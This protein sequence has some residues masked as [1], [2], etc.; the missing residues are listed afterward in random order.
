MKKKWIG[1]LYYAGPIRTKLLLKMKL[2]TFLLCL[3]VA[4][5]AS[6]TYSQQ[7]KFTMN[8]EN[9][10]V[11]QVFQKVE[12]NSEFI[13]LYSEQSVDLTREVTVSVTNKTVSD[14][15]DQL[16][17]GT[18]NYYEIN[19]RQISILEKKVETTPLN[20]TIPEVKDKEQ[21]QKKSI[22]GKVTDTNGEPLPGVTVVVKGTTIGITTDFD[23]NYA[24]EV[25]VDAEILSFS[26]VGMK[27]QDVIIA[28]QTQIS[29]TLEEETIGLEEVVAIGYGVQKKKLTTGANAQVTG[30]VLFKQNTTETLSALQGQASGIQIS[31]NS[32]QPGSDF[33]INI[34]GLGTNG[35]ATPLYV[36]DGIPTSSIS[37]LSP[38]D[39]ES[40]DVLKDAASAAIY[41]ARA[42]N[43]VVLVTTKQ[44]KAGK[45]TI[46]LDSYYGWQNLYKKLDLLNA[47]EYAMI[48]NESWVSAGNNSLYDPLNP[49][50]FA[51]TVPNWDKIQNGIWMGTDWL[52]EIRVKNAPTQN[53]SLNITGGTDKS[54]Y[55][56]GIS[57]NQQKGILGKPV[58]SNYERV[59][60][61]INSDH[62]LIE[63]NELTILK[64]GENLNFSMSK[65]NSLPTGSA[66]YNFLTRF[67][68]MHPFSSAY[69]EEG[70]YKDAIPWSTSGAH[71]NPVG[72]TDYEL[73]Q[74]IS[75]N[76]TLLGNLY[77]ELQPIDNL[78]WRNSIGI[79]NGLS[80]NRRFVPEYY[81]SPA[82]DGQNLYSKIFQTMESSI[83]WIYESTISYD[84]RL[85]EE[86]NFDVLTGTSLQHTGLGESIGGQNGYSTFNDLEH[87]YLSN[88]PVINATYT[89]LYGDPEVENVILSFFGRLN[90]NFKET[91]LFTA[92][93]RADGS[94]NFAS[95][96]R[97]GYFP[98]FS[99]GWIMTN[100]EFMNKSKSWL[101]YFKLRASWGQ[102]GNQN[103]G[104]FAYSSNI[105]FDGVGASY[106]Y[107]T[108]KGNRTLGAYPEKIANP[109]LIWETSEQTNFGF[110]AKL[111][112]SRMGLNI[113]VYRK[114]TKDWLVDAPVLDSYGTGAPTI[115][116]G[117]VRNQGVEL[118]LS[119]NDNI[120]EFRYGFNG[121][122][123][124]NQNKVTKVANEEGFIESD[125][126]GFGALQ[127]AMVGLPFS[128]F[129]GRKTD[130]VFQNQSDIQAYINED[131]SLIQPD[132][133]P[134]DFRYVDIN[135]DGIIND[136]DRTNIGKSSPDYTFGLSANAEFK[137]VDLSITANG[138][139]GNQNAMLYH[140]S[141][142][143]T[144]RVYK[145]NY[146][147]EILN[148]WHGEGSSNTVPRVAQDATNFTFFSDYFVRDAGYLR[149][150]NITLGYDIKKGFRKIPFSQLRI[151]CSVQNLY[152]FT[153]YSGMDPEVGFGNDQDSEGSSPSWT[154]G[155]DLGFYPSPRTFLIGANIKF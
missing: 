127:R 43:G 42:A 9:I 81:L 93:M 13:F 105:I 155:I 65:N 112:N 113:D 14:I 74:N 90:Y 11:E 27:T 22:S 50:G 134:G 34:R 78:I 83:G 53:H 111:F 16:F 94:S 98:S 107:G 139:T 56:I 92:V 31:K 41:G 17:E 35:D 15:L 49:D 7:T 129:W 148:R 150:S 99:T 152:T 138:V 82:I 64:V 151:Y 69:D 6:T 62:K 10:T 144:F 136:N 28:G 142:N 29:V 58:E 40:L 12:D 79:D 25:P 66:Y 128:V 96:N 57:Y 140:M 117:D 132:A 106:F 44:G 125:S 116:G 54:V 114:T 153:K 55:S 120:G 77:A 88:T 89:S 143:T 39:I 46:T 121:N 126:R 147:T 48:M 70:S 18:Q 91:Y 102:N 26:F 3:S 37:F 30:D 101:D 110:D 87:A 141:S 149:I 19:D 72:Y 154:S 63:K 103:I 45:T 115:N 131:G 86:H 73:G 100:E 33:K 4:S 71:V 1:L 122:I 104:A 52:E 36:V 118:A 145:S 75:K 123:S 68:I 133:E 135:E 38:S 8:F 80:R 67:T 108:D 119:W 130:G 21:E 23:G 109:D 76:Q 137:G 2:L 97:W 51:Q 24:L 60:I 146:T 32:G 59:T 95:N 61:R 20:K 84:F 85:K 5:I 47:Q 124:Y